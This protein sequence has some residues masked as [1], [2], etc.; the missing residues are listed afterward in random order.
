MRSHY[1]RLSMALAGGALLAGLAGANRA[2]RAHASAAPES[3]A[4]LTR[5]FQRGNWDYKSI[6][7][8]AFSPSGVLFFAD[9][10]AGAIYGVDLGET[11][12]RAAAYTKVP[13]LGATLAARLGTT[14]A[15]IQIRDLAVSPVSRNVYL[16]VR[17]MAGGSQNAAD[18]ANY[19]LFAVDPSGKVRPV[20]LAGRPFGRVAIAGQPAYGTQGDRQ[21]ISDIAYA[22]GRVLV[23]A[24][25]NEQFNSNLVSVPVPFNAGGVERYATSIYH[26]SHHRQETASPIQTL[27][28]CRDGD[29]EYLM[30]AYVC[31]PVVRFNLEELKPGQVVKGTTV[32]ELGSGNRPMDMVAYGKDGQQALLLNNSVFGVM[33]VDAKIAREATAVNEQTAASRGPGG[34][35]AYPGLE[36][37]SSLKGAK[38]YAPGSDGS[39]LVVMPRENSLALEAMPLP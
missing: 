33:K 19:A 15:G 23:A 4:A 36:V 29:R 37:V 2:P 3:K 11:P 39:L 10:Q 24:L 28:V 27:T 38:A 1:F 21:I 16:S 22:R 25:S 12:S 26:V 20:D 7:A 31:T 17:K 35:T 5:G 6:G 8:L 30:G 14:P 32:A 9:D 18:P 13:D 34:R